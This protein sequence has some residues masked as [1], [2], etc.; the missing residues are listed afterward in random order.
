MLPCRGLRPAQL[1]PLSPRHPVT[2]RSS[3][4]RKFSS[5]PRTAGLSAPSC[6]ASP[7]QSAR[8]RTGTASRPNV[9]LTA[10]A[11]RN[12]SW[13]APWS[14]G[15][16]SGPSSDI[17]AAGAEQ[18]PVAEFVSQPTSS[19]VEP[20]VTSATPEI[21]PA[22]I[23]KAPVTNNTWETSTTAADSE[24]AHDPKTID[25]LLGLE[26]AK[27]VIPKAEIDPTALIDHAGQLQELGLEYGWGMTTMFEKIIEQIYLNTG[28]GWAG[29]IMLAGVVVRCSTFFFQALSSDKMAALAALKPVTE[30]IQKKM[31]E[32]IARGDKTQESIYKMQM[33][34]VMRPYIGSMGSMGGFMV[35]QAWIGFCAFR[36]LRAMGEMPVPGMAQDGFA[37]FTDLTVRDPYFILPA[38]TTAIFYAIFKTG[39]EVG[40]SND[41][42]GKAAQRQKLMTGMAFLLGIVTAFQAAGLQI[43]FLVQGVLGAGTGYLLRQNGFRRFIRI[44]PLPSKE[45]TEMYSQVIK[46]EKKLAD[47]KSPD[48]KVRY[49]APKSTSANPAGLNRRNATTLAGIKVKAGTPLPAHLKPETPK[50][51]K[52]RPDRDADF[53]EG[54]KGTAMEKLDYYR[55]NYRLAFVKRRMEKGMKNMVR[56]A[57]YGGSDASDAQ[58]KRKDRADR[59]E[60]ERRRR[61]E[62]RK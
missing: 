43:Y 62:N 22:G 36:F 58:Q 37:W 4:S 54:A 35:I 10:S 45:S 47:I 59:Y 61:F 26:P 9:V 50:I 48:G 31:E 7:L 49:Q 52:D 38:A 11:V 1:A 12:G 56:G 6:R 2:L 21:A 42:G 39:G 33:A 53:E 44:R 5:L 46:G 40:I 57:G 41:V 60:I 14:W 8:W 13:Y 55:R 32:A 51:D 24:A 18:V 27:D 16:S 34:Q 19:H 3:A 25:D 15:K 20:V 28:Y 23:D 29:S 17:P 30:P